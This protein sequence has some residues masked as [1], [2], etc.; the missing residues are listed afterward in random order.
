MIEL[1]VVELNERGKR[2]YVSMENAY[3]GFTD[4]VAMSL[5][6]EQL[7]AIP[8]PARV[9]KKIM[10]EIR[11]VRLKRIKQYFQRKGSNK[12]RHNR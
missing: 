2:F 7:R 11:R 3:P 8:L 9:K 6:I 10:K 5:F 4:T 1:D 12:G